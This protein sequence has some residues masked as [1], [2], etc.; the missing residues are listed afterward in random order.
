LALSLKNKERRYEGLS[1]VW[2]GKIQGSRAKAQYKEGEERI[3]EGYDILKELSLRPAMAQGHFHLG[4]L[5]GNSG[6]NGKAVEELRRAETMFEEMAMDY[7]TAKAR[8]ALRGL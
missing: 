2:I 1:K 6:E 4:E 5:Y 8:E 7:W 3:L